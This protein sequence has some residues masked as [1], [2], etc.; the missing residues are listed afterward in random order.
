MT[1]KQMI[2]TLLFPRIL[3]FK[4]DFLTHDRKGL[5]R[6][7]VLFFLGLLFWCGIFIVF[8]RVLLYF[9]GIEAIGD[10][11]ATKLLS[12]VFL[13]LFSVLI[14][15]NIVT[16]LSTYFLSDDLEFIISRPV[17]SGELYFSRFIETLLNSSWMT[18]LF[19]FPVFLAY[20]MVYHPGYLYYLILSGVIIPFLIIPA[21]IGIIITLILV[22]ILPARRLK[23]ILILLSILFFIA[24]YFFFRL[25][26]P[27]RLVD[28][29]VFSG[30][31][32][33]I[34]SLKAP[35]SPFLPSQ[36]T[37]DCLS[38]ILLKGT[39]DYFSLSLLFITGLAILAIGNEIF[40]SMYF[41]AW[42][43]SQ[44]AK[45]AK[46]SRSRWMNSFL[47]RMV[48]PFSPSTQALVIKDLKI[49][50]RDTHQWPQL[51]LIFA[52]ITIY[53][54]NFSVLPLDK[55]PLPTFY[56]QNLVSFL[57]LGLAGFAL[58]AVAV[59]FSFPAVSMEGKSFWIIQSSPLDLRRF[60]KTKFWMNFFF[61]FILAEILT[62]YSNYLLNATPFIMI[63]SA[64]TIGL[65]TLGITSLGIGLGSYFPRFKVENVAQI[66]TG[67]GGVVYMILAIS[68]IGLIVILE[69]RPVY[70]LFMARLK[71]ASLTFWE[72]LE[73][74][75]S[76][77]GVG[78]INC[79]AFFLP[80]K[81]G[82]EKLSHLEDV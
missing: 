8:Y 59:R 9:Q 54:Y 48:R 2:T 29:E 26:Q 24:L 13:C 15:S 22:S 27:E 49:F 58:A 32:E 74:G 65:M 55:S 21:G 14:F 23:D 75:L 72:G 46:I 42:S 73:I 70:I 63:L 53:L 16:A 52:L 50:F 36:W 5:V 47:D 20:G 79:L 76:F 12:M 81:I 64:V 18:L 28:P 80:L 35:I 68:F 33:Y 6:D 4:K 71:M 66:P 60:I 45:T 31:M 39:K 11:L 57:N 44:E 7:L 62:I 30:L 1:G 69:A 3:S 77:L 38:P 78:V 82:V 10:I 41:D 67:F 56:L 37:V 40:S 51:F 17:S 34:A 19:G 61:L 25:L 43:K